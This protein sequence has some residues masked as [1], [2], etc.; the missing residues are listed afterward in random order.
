MPHPDVPAE[1]GRLSGFENAIVFREQAAPLDGP[2]P[3]ERVLTPERAVRMALARDPRIQAALAKVRVAEAEAH[4]ARLLPNPV[5][6]IDIRYAIEPSNTAFEPSLTADLLSLL[7]KPAA[8]SAA[9]DRLRGAA[10]DAV[11]TVLD[12]IEEVQEAYAS[13]RSV[14]LEIDNATH[15]RERLRR[16]RDIA[17]NRLK[18]GEA[19]GLDVVTVDAQVM[20]TELELSDLELQRSDER[21]VLNRLLGYVRS[22][23]EWELSAWRPPAEGGLAPESAW[24]D[25]A[26]ANRPEVGS[27]VG[28]LR[29]LGEE[30]RGAAIP[31]IQGG[32]IGAHGE[33]DPEWRL[34]PVVSVPLPIF[35]FGQATREKVRAERVA[36]RHALD[37][38]RL[39]VVQNVRSTYAGYLHSRRVLADTQDKLLPLQRRQLESA[40]LAYQSGEADLATLLLA[41]NEYEVTLG[42]I[43]ELEEKVTVARA[44]LMRAAGGAGVGAKLTSPATQPATAPVAPATVPSERPGPEEPAAKPAKS[45]KSAK[46]AASQP[47][48]QPASEPVSQPAAGAA[49]AVR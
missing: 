7:Q 32:E 30:V 39:D 18:A 8:I 1:A 44:K 6:T 43:V 5:L 37:Q 27:K 41:Q 42:K 21:L 31:P 26:L 36:A 2:E 28:E 11:A 16:L 4:Q 35:D 49:G 25:A 19:T 33:H 10:A 15:R 13:A 45:A 12:V 29:A 38:A 46:S 24:V 3:V 17:Q 48:S 14:E 22:D 9:D 34:G 47:V 23:V 40:K 20:Q